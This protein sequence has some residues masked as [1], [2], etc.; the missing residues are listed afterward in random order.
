MKAYEISKNEA[1]I[2]RGRV[3]MAI[4]G[5]EAAVEAIVKAMASEGYLSTQCAEFGDKDGEI[6][7]YFVIGRANKADFMNTYKMCK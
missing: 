5:V 6:V 2:P 3:L 1:D 7:E 4:E